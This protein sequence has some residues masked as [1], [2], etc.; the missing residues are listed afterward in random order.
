MGLADFISGLGEFAVAAFC[1]F[2]ADR[3]GIEQE[4]TAMESLM[5]EENHCNIT[6]LFTGDKMHSLMPGTPVFCKLAGGAAEHA[7]ICIG[8]KI[9]HLDG[10]GDI[11]CT[12][13]AAFLARKNG[14]NMA[15]NIYY[16]AR[17][18][19]TPL[20]D[21]QVAERAQS[22]IGRHQ[23]YSVWTDN[24]LGFTLGC[25][26]GDFDQHY[27]YCLGEIERAISKHWGTSDWEWRNWDFKN[28]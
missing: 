16:A 23:H 4:E 7:G 22:R 27:N 19:D 21:A 12:S 25:I 24:C 1:D 26:T 10:S 5:N 2:A 3:L 15:V 17:S 18:K 6:Q 28:A 20:G 13:P 9:V 11:I 8:R 14:S